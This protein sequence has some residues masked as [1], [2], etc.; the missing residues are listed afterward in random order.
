MYAETDP[1]AVLRSGPKLDRAAARKL[2]DDLF[3]GLA[4]QDAA[5]AEGTLG[6]DAY[7]DERLV[8][9]ASFPGLDIVCHRDLQIDKP[10]TLPS[11]LI[12][13]ARGRSVYLHAMHSVTDWCAF[14]YWHKGRL[15]R[16]LSISPDDGVIEDV[17][18]HLPFEVPYWSGDHPVTLDDDD[19]DEEAYPLPF[20]PLELGEE[21]LAYFFGFHL[22][23]YATDLDPM[24][25]PLAAFARKA[26]GR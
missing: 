5:S 10:S 1:V 2:L 7:P 11:D 26:R 12:Q 9:A 16:A 18:E 6:D 23:G 20:H 8:C 25:I 19:D 17:G 21:A 3:P 4:G 14:A 15:I 22:E 13:A 24:S